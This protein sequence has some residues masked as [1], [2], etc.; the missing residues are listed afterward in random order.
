MNTLSRMKL[1]SPIGLLLQIQLR[2]EKGW[3]LMIL[4]YIAFGLLLAFTIFMCTHEF[5]CQ[6]IASRRSKEINAFLE[7]E[8]EKRR[9]RLK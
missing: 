4:M 3:G 7:E 9:N 2:N 6:K 5:E 1:I 8:L